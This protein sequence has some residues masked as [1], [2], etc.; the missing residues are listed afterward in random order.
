MNKLDIRLYRMIEH[1]RGQFIS[2]AVIVVVALSIFICFS[3]SNVNIRE[4]IKSF[5]DETNF[6]HINVELMK[7]SQKGIKEI[8]SI[9][10]IKEVQGRVSVDVPLETDNKDEKVILR[11]ISVPGD[12]GI[13]RLHMSGGEKTRLKNNNLIL[14]RQFALDRD[15]EK[16]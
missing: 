10:G 11:L 9:E 4:A 3:T 8:K 14:L 5:Y 6:S 2:V 12:D 15:I 1:S 16:G 13:N 7:I